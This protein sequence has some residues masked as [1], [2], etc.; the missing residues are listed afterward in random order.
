MKNLIFAVF[1]FIV[2]LLVYLFIEI[3]G[4][5]KDIQDI[6]LKVDSI[7]QDVNCNQ[8]AINDAYNILEKHGK[9]L[10]EIVGLL[11]HLFPI[12]FLSYILRDFF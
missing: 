4:C 7:K 9:Y 1:V 2:G 6:R 10:R 8:Q 12:K 5:K 11:S 3:N